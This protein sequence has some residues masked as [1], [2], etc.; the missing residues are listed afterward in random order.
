MDD[1]GWWYIQEQRRREQAEREARMRAQAEQAR[2]RE[3]MITRMQVRV[4]NDLR[5]QASKGARRQQRMW[6]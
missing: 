4:R 6:F 2:Q 3:E 1:N 5:P